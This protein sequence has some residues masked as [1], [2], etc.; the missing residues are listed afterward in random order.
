MKRDIKDSDYY[1]EQGRVHFTND[2]L[3]HRGPCCG[4]NCRHCPYDVS[5]KGNTKLRDEL[6]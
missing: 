4:G 1:L 5:I 2:Y 3:F 6:D